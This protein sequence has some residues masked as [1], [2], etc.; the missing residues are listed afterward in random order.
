MSEKDG[1]GATP[2]PNAVTPDPN[3]TPDPREAA[4]GDAGK[5]LL[6]ELRRENK[7]LANTVK[8][9]AERAKGEDD[10]AAQ[11]EADRIAA[12]EADRIAAEDKDK[13]SDQKLEERLAAMQER[14]VKREWKDAAR[15]AGILDT[16]AANDLFKLVTD[17]IAG[18]PDRISDVI[19]SQ[20]K[21]RP[22]FFKEKPGTKG[23][24]GG[25]G[26]QS[27]GPA[28]TADEKMFAKLTGTSEEDYLA[29]KQ[30]V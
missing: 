7:E 3:A 16:K 13:S 11:A 27:G 5:E 10:A 20:L 9:L 19:A 26:K 12:E 4:L 14:L 8:S 15:E 2:D 29:G 28:L 22:N 6:K 30:T 24:G 21:E 23:H 18:D 17:E 25:G 1:T